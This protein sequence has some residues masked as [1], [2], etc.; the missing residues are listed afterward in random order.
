MTAEHDLAADMCAATDH[1]L[2][3]LPADARTALVNWAAAYLGWAG[4]KTRP[5]RQTTHPE[6]AHRYVE[7]IKQQIRN[8]KSN[9]HQ[10][11]T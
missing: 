9:D 2:D 1:D 7:G 6:I 11:T 8:A 5:R 4:S 3:E 10:E